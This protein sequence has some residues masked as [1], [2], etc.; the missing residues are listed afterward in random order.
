M[1]MLNLSYQI[2]GIFV[3]E[4]NT[5]LECQIQHLIGHLLTYQS[6]VILFM[7]GIL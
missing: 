5:C 4:H 7:W 2:Q 6:V 1:S 3:C